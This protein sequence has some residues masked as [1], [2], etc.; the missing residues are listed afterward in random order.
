MGGLRISKQTSRRLENRTLD[1]WGLRGNGK[2]E[3][4]KRVSGWRNMFGA[5][6]FGND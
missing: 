6:L 1:G 2:Y 4:E 3:G 5:N